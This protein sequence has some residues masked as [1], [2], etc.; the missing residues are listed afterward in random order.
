MF[1]SF[2]FTFIINIYIQCVL[3]QTK[4]WLNSSILIFTFNFVLY[5]VIYFFNNMYPTTM[6]HNIINTVLYCCSGY[7]CI[8]LTVISV[9]E[10]FF[11]QVIHHMALVI[12]QYN[13]I[14]W[15]CLT[16]LTIFVIA[17]TI[18]IWLFNKNTK[19]SSVWLNRFH[20]T[21]CTL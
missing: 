13:I 20:K 10:L 7:T 12:Q 3:Y 5:Q 8:R 9:I 6:T 21:W 15:L 17:S 1:I 2:Y 19:N 11:I 18:L 14:V 4:L 16:I